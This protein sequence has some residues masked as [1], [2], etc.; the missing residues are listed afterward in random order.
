MLQK[1]K[2]KPYI[3]K[4]PNKVFYCDGDSCIDTKIQFAP[5]QKLN[6]FFFW[7]SPHV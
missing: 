6:D 7:L 3:K 1:K 5:V 4:K 2:K